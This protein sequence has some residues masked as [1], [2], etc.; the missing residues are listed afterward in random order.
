MVLYL[1]DLFH[2]CV[3]IF[4]RERAARCAVQL[5]YYYVSVHVV[6]LYVVRVVVCF[7]VV[8]CL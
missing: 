1:S 2:V 7:S 5:H 3:T 4:M 8:S 6:L